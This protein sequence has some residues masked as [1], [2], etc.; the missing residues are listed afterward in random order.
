MTT[1]NHIV[2]TQLPLELDFQSLKAAGLAYIQKHSST[3]WTNLNP[4]DP[5]ITILEQL[6]YAFTELGYCANFPMKDILTQKNGSLQVENQFYT[7]KD[8][9]TTSPIT[10][11]DYTMLV[12]DQIA[13][14]KNIII[15]PIPTAFPFVQGIY[16]VYLLLDKNYTDPTVEHNPEF[17]TFFLLNNVRNIAEVFLMPTTLV[18]K[19]YSITGNLELKSGYHYQDVLPKIIQSISQYVFP[20]VTQTGYDKLQKEGESTSAIFNGPILKNGWIPS[21]SIQPKKDTIQ[22]FEITKLIHDIE[23]VQA[24]SNVTFYYD[25]E[26]EDSATCNENEIL[27]FDFTQSLTSTNQLKIHS[28]GA[29]HNLDVNTSLLEEFG[30]MQ[31]LSSKINTV[32]AVVTEPSLPEGKFRDITNYYAIQNTFP[33]AYKVGLNAVNKNTPAYQTAQSRQL[34]GYLNVFDQMLSNQFAQ[35][36]NIDKLF[37]FKNSITGSP[38]DLEN[39]NATKTKEQKE[40]PKYPAPFKVFSPTYFYQ[41]LYGSVPNIEPLL[42]DY[43]TFN[44]GPVLETE[45]EL[46]KK[47]WTLYQED[48]YNAYM[49]GLLVAIEEDAINLQ[50]RND[51]LDHLLARHGES[52]AVIDTIIYGTIYSG[53]VLKDRVIIK[54]VYLQNLATLSYHKTKAYNTIGSTI[55]NNTFTEV[56]AETISD[57]IKESDPKKLSKALQ[58]LRTII[59]KSNDRETIFNCSYI[60]ASQKVTKQDCIDYTTIIL[61]MQLLLALEQHYI[62]YLQTYKSFD[63][64]YHK[65]FYLQSLHLTEIESLQKSTALWLISERKGLISVETNILLQSAGF[66]VYIKKAIDSLGG[67]FKYYSNN[68]MLS[69]ED[70]IILTTSFDSMTTDEV[71]TMLSDT[72]KWT[73]NFENPTIENDRFD[74]LGTSDYTYTIQISWGTEFTTT[75]HNPI[76][77]NTLLFYFPD[78]ITSLNATAYKQRLS[79]FLKSQ[80][81]LHVSTRTSYIDA[82][83]MS[84]LIP[85]FSDWHNALLYNGT[86][87]DFD[88]TLATTTAGQL[89]SHLDKL[90]KKHA[91]V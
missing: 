16:N 62:N 79:Y 26:K 51:L 53:D 15:A 5:G 89:I 38:A 20:D 78:F 19:T 17:D 8:I 88:T 54:S 55:I 63:F 64:Y 42:L 68:T 4:S 41:S 2:D 34:K 45:D 36:A 9:L 23:G 33:E 43:T 24:I 91:N 76:F 46:E 67:K 40:N 83:D 49:Y 60:D 56:T 71:N 32:A 21:Q 14:V 13:A 12:I 81:P 52:P 84:N 3:A 28:E 50:R 69:Y 85:L 35:L 77:D 10:I 74:T 22:P 7:P 18:E 11:D 25:S 6:C 82:T 31:Q 57:V 61:K 37:S 75:I 59:V 58:L 47:K 65:G 73:M 27:V 44:F 48:P 80:L 72:S 86:N 1:E 87:S 66:T 70:F 90:Y 39:Y 29:Q 30:S